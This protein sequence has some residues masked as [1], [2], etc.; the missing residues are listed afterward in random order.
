MTT[1]FD[2]C[3]EPQLGVV[4]EGLDDG[5]ARMRLS[6]DLRIELISAERE[7]LYELL[8][9]GRITDESRRRLERELDLEEATILSRREGQTPL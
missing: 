5:L 3:A 2:P 7:F 6:N 8:R 1:F 4:R 9:Q